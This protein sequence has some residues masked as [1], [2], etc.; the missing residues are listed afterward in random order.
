MAD[1][2]LYTLSV[3]FLNRATF[4]TDLVEK[5]SLL[6]KLATSLRDALLCASKLAPRAD[7]RQLGNGGTLGAN[8]INALASLGVTLPPAQLEALQTLNFEPNGTLSLTDLNGLNDATD[9]NDGLAPLLR[10]ADSRSGGFRGIWRL[11]RSG[12]SHGCLG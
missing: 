9:L 12:G 11:P 10:P 6:P 7:E 5:H 1:S 4:V 2:S 3:Q 8:A